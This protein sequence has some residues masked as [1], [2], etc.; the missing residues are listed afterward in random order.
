MYRSASTDS[1]TAAAP[2][3]APAAKPGGATMVPQPSP[4]I[5]IPR[6]PAG[7]AAPLGPGL[8]PAA[9][10]MPA[11]GATPFKDA[12]GL[13]WILLNDGSF[14]CIDAP[15]ARQAELHVHVSRDTDAARFASLWSA[16]QAVRG[17]LGDVVASELPMP[18]DI[19]IVQEGESPRS[20]AEMHGITKEAL[21]EA[22]EDKV[23]WMDK[24]DRKV[25][26]FLPGEK[27]VI[28]HA[29]EAPPPAPDEESWWEWGE[30]VGREIGDDIGDGLRGIRDGISD[31]I[32]WLEDQ[33]W[34]DE[35]EAPV[36][37]APDTAKELPQET[38]DLWVERAAA[39]SKKKHREDKNKVPYDVAQ[40]DAWL[41]ELAKDQA[42]TTD[43]VQLRVLAGVQFQFESTKRGTIYDFGSERDYDLEGTFDCSEAVQWMLMQAG[44]DD[45][46]GEAG[47]RSA[48]PYMIDL[49]RTVFGDQYRAEPRVGDLMM[50]T[51]HVGMVMDVRPDEDAFYA[52]HMSTSGSF[53]NAFKLSDPV[54]SSTKWGK[55]LLGFWSPEEATLPAAIGTVTVKDRPKANKYSV[56]ALTQD[57]ALGEFYQ[58][59]EKLELLKI[60]G[61]AYLVHHAGT[62]GAAWVPAAALTRDEP[63]P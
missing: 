49:I 62:R 15:Y 61:A 36:E 2:D 20:I 31:G 43:Q 32:D 40:I 45:L 30:R 17:A 54:G 19:H 59:G 35:P 1:S 29:V 63:A 34:G 53:F 3:V 42:A 7:G 55:G 12:E 5:G 57:Q 50:W 25:P 41:P 22:N 23:K 9:P 52:S 47:Q 8:A 14:E 39:L 27:L 38:I 58:P 4:G 26:F 44:L 13:G 10:G 56:P 21:L 18:V 33:I 46:F 48:T 24:G 16:W 37:E 6:A 60:E 51:G 11:P 28:P